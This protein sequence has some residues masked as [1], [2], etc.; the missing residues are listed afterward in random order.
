MAR[1]WR[2]EYPGALYHVL[3]RGDRREP[4]V[5]ALG[6]DRVLGEEGIPKDSPAGRREFERRLEARRRQEEPEAY[7]TER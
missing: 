5:K 6:V 4:I 3:N 1:R 7:A 2:I